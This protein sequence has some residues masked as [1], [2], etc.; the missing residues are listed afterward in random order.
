VLFVGCHYVTPG[1]RISIFAVIRNR[2]REPYR[3]LVFADLDAGDVCQDRAARALICWRLTPILGTRGQFL[4]HQ[5]F[6]I[7]SGHA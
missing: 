5:S 7:R 2:R 3:Y 6:D 4:K 1:D